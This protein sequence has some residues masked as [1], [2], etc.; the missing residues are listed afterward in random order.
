MGSTRILRPAVT[1]VI[2]LSA[3][4]CGGGGGGN[5]PQPNPPAPNP[6]SS[7]TVGGMVAG[8]NGT[9]LVLQNSGGDNLTINGSGPFTFATPISQGNT[10][11]V[12]I[13]T[14]PSNP[15]QTCVVSNGSGTVGAANV[16]SVSIA[17]SGDTFAVSANVT[18]LTGAGLVIANGPDRITPR[19]DG[20]FTFDTRVASGARYNVLIDA[21]PT[22]PAQRCTIANGNGMIANANV[23]VQI[24]CAATFPTFAYNLNQADGTLASYAIDATNGQMRPRSLAKTGAGPAQLT[25]YKSP[26]GQRFGYVANQDSDS[27][28]AFAIDSRT[29][30]LT[31]VPGSPFTSGGD[32]PTLLTLHPTLPF[33]YAVNETGASIAAYTINTNTGV[34][35]AIGPVT[36]GS[37]PRAFSIE[38]SGRF[39]YVA[40]SGPGELITY[41]IDQT[42]SA[43]SEVPNSRV[44][45]GTSFGGMTLERNGRFVYAF[46]SDGG[47]IAA[48]AINATTGVP[49]AIAGSPIAAGINIK[50]LGTHPNGRFIYA[51]RGP[52]TE[53]VANGV[54]V[55]ALDETTGALSEITGSPFDVSA[56][57]IA[58]TFDPTGR[59]MY[60]GHLLVQGSAEVNVRAYSVDPNTGALTAISGSPFAAPAFPASLDVDSTGKYLYV[61]STQSNQLT[62]YRIDSSDGSLSQLTNS[63]ANAGAS[64]TVIT[65]EEDTTPLSLS[66]KFV[67]VTDPA[68]NIRSFNIAA[69]G[70]LSAG[71]VTT[72]IPTAPLGITLDPQ[73]RFAYVADPGANAVRIYAVN[74]STGALSEIAGSPAVTGGNPQYVAIEP[75]GRYAYVSIPGTPSI[76]KYSIDASTGDLSSAVSKNVTDDIQDL[77]IAPNG[78]WLMATAATG[79]TVYSYS[80]DV[81]TGD[82]GTEVALDLG[83]MVATGSLAVD[84]SGK[85][86]YITDTANS[87]L[88]QLQIN[89][90]TGALSPLGGPVAYGPG[91]VPTA[92]ALDPKG[93]FAFTA[94]SGSNSVSIFNINANG[95]LGY[96]GSVTGVTNP[97]AITTDYSGQFVLVATGG[98]ELLTFRIDRDARNLT[99]VDT[100]TGVGAIAEPGTI[101]TSS[102][103]E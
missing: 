75:S 21:A 23:T 84:L 56:N 27:V 30:A 83:P 93:G 98:G 47:T 4:G 46:N 25:L 41:A 35:S 20:S 5:T 91:R 49:A 58:I 85:F 67:Y 24:T 34:L 53:T 7:Y 64:P 14:Q 45:I 31:Q 60:A 33:I 32:K 18:G 77:V 43:L 88:R 39:A 6:P 11:N 52:Q 42:T 102:H 90:Q 61:A 28:S 57:P 89:A 48:F 80:I 72:G 37:S 79:T 51:K 73:G 70:M 71:A 59:N 97:I 96:R 63:P 9:G 82:L 12:T 74:A 100:E 40:A 94:D 76:V 68:S 16:T 15:Q 1:L 87:T 65:T 19:A 99:P 103:A 55:F 66:S 3:T 10:Y 92:I 2:L 86:A 26:S 44:A 13:L 62:A 78:R 17:C 54:A 22:E 29:G 81:S 8:L 50:L 69:D 95:S 101:V 36:T 38:A